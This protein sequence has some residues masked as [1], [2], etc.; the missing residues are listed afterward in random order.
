MTQSPTNTPGLSRDI[1]SKLWQA[2]DKLRGHLDA[3]EYKHVVLGLIFLKYI[4]DTFQ[5]MHDRLVNTPHADPEDRDEYTA[6]GIFW[7]PKEARWSMLA[8]NAKQDRI[9]VLIDEAMKALE[10]DNPSLKGV[11]PQNYARPDLDKR[12][13]GEIIDLIGTIAMGDENS[14]SHDVLGRVYEY[15][16]SQFASAEGKKG[17]EFYTP[18]SVV[19]LL[20][21]MLEPYKGRVYDPCC[22]SGGMF[23]QSEAFIEAHG[24]KVNDLSVFGTGEQPDDLEAVQDESCH[25]RHREQSW[26]PCGGHL[27]Q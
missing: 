23:V 12:R 18:K 27:P 22:G 6:E 20:V 4:S 11:L 10:T 7:V 24:G 3:A 5:E 8:D 19:R 15:F 2:A 13:V 26:H 1:E 17:G 21:E 9:G 14:Q 16:L 25:S